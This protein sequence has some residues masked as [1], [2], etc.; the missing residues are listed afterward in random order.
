MTYLVLHILFEPPPRLMM[1]GNWDYRAWE[2]CLEGGSKK[3]VVASLGPD[4][5]RWS[6]HFFQ[7]DFVKEEARTGSSRHR[8]DKEG[9]ENKDG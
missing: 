6:L 4:S 8:L 5:H 1:K 9:L 7:R 3:W 2:W